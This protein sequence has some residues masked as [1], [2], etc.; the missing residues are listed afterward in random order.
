MKYKI[1]S[2]D[3]VRCIAPLLI[4]LLSLF[5]A[6]QWLHA[7]TG[8]IYMFT[9]NPELEQG[10]HG[11]GGFLRSLGYNVT[12][13]PPGGGPYRALDEDSPSVQSNKIAELQAYDLI[14]I[15][16]NFGSAILNSSSTELSIWNQMKV[17]L[18][19]MNGP[20]ILSDIPPPYST[21]LKLRWKWINVHGN[22]NA[23]QVAP[24]MIL[25]ASNNA[26]NH[27]IVADLDVAD[28]NHDGTSA[29]INLFTTNQFFGGDGPVPPPYGPDEGTIDGGTNMVLVGHPEVYGIL[30]DSVCL[31]VWDAANDNNTPKGF[32]SS[33]PPPIFTG[34]TYY[35]RLPPKLGI[36]RD[37]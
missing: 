20:V 10:S 26:A 4:I 24:Y 5:L 12:V 17:P 22:A 29:E 27:P 15:H 32:F 2:P 16:R 1:V 31:A 33:T 7:A 28:F 19:C 11:I 35:R 13:E 3:G 8:N 23:P 6:P 36:Q 18:L 9:A 37:G 14:I 34:E 25:A 30:A 21:T